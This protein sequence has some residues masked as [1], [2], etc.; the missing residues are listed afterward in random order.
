MKFD[1]KFDTIDDVVHHVATLWWVCTGYHAPS[2][3][4]EDYETYPPFR[5]T[6]LNR[7]M[8]L[9]DVE[10]DLHEEDL[11]LALPYPRKNLLVKILIQG[12]T[13][14]TGTPSLADEAIINDVAK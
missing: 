14:R 1:S 4:V 2:F 10:K 6:H 11:D 9:Y 8:P 13:D 7:P 12:V 5:P 3:G